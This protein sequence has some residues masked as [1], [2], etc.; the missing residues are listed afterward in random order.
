MKYEYVL[1]IM[2]LLN[3]EMAHVPKIISHEEKELPIINISNT[4][5]ANGLGLFPIIS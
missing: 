2:L 3:I 5:I 4:L 1:Y